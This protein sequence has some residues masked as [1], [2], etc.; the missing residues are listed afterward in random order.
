MAYVLGEKSLAKLKGVHPRLVQVVKRAIVLT[1]QD[2]AVTDGLRTAEQQRVLVQKGASKTM[3]SKHLKQ[4]DGWGHAVDLVP[5]INGGP[6]WEWEPIW[7]IAVAVDQASTELNVNLIWGAI[8]DTP[9]MKYGG[10]PAEL[11]AAV[12]AYKARRRKLGKSAF[13]DG[14][15]YQLAEG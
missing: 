1:K 14:P 4:R 5:F 6:R 2:F 3:L 11:K 12:E 10:G 7:N 8:W 13:L 9:M 15:H